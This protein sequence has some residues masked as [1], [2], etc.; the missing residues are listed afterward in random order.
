MGDVAFSSIRGG[1][2]A[3]GGIGGGVPSSMS[4]SSTSNGAPR[5]GG[6][7]YFS[8]FKK[9]EVNELLQWLQ[10]ASLERNT[11]KQREA[12]KRVIAYMTIGIDVSRLFP[13]MMMV[14]VFLRYSKSKPKNGRFGF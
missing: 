9:G 7:S 2:S 14:S 11:E 8:E 6:S 1:G 5:G 13:E 3:S 12:V 4:T 10:E